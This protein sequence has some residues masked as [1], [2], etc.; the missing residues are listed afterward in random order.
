M[1]CH[2]LPQVPAPAPCIRLMQ[3]QL[4]K[5]RSHLQGMLGTGT[6]VVTESGVHTSSFEVD[7]AID[8]SIYDVK[9]GSDHNELS[10][11]SSYILFR[12]SRNEVVHHDHLK[13]D[14]CTQVS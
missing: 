2:K 9:K 8:Y 3:E 5:A 13:Q 12:S 10:K 7:E 6:R 4:T 1:K 11:A 14:S